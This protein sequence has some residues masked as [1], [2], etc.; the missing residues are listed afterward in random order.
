MHRS[1]YMGEAIRPRRPDT[2]AVPDVGGVG[3]RPR[4]PNRGAR[5]RAALWFA[6]A[7]KGPRAQVH[8]APHR[9]RP[10]IP[11]VGHASTKADMR[12]SAQIMAVP[13]G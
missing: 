2:E 10:N 8:R 6:Y 11:R 4:A 12:P 9:D 3:E 5:K 7:A 13:F 1:Q